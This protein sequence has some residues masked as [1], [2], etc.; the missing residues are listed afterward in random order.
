MCVSTLLKIK[1]KIKTI[2]AIPFAIGIQCSERERK[3]RAAPIDFI[4]DT[5]VVLRHCAGPFLINT[6]YADVKLPAWTSHLLGPRLLG[7]V[8]VKYL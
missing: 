1:R 5:R 8:R 3:T 6:S 2:H 4:D 7:I